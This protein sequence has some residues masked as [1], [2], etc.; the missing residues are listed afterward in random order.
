MALLKVH[1][2]S[3]TCLIKKLISNTN[4]KM[5]PP[6]SLDQIRGKV[7]KL[8]MYLVHDIYLHTKIEIKRGSSSITL[9]FH[10]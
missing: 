10:I 1:S 2:L 6:T 7:L 5:A 9:F 8:E 4:L 3:V